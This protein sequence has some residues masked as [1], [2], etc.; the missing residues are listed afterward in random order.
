[1]GSRRCKPPTPAT[2]ERQGSASGGVG[3][4]GLKEVLTSDIGAVIL[5]IGFWGPLYCNYNK[6]PQT[7]LVMIK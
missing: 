4:S 7:V 3:K 5:R 6:D 1:M 2:V